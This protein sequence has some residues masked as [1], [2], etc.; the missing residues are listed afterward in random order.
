M[1]ETSSKMIL[2]KLTTAWIFCLAVVDA[3]PASKPY[4]P[5]RTSALEQ[6]HLH[7]A[8]EWTEDT[9]HS[10]GLSI[11][12]ERS[13]PDDFCPLHFS[14]GVSQRV[15]HTNHRNAGIVAP[16]IIF[17]ILPS[18]GPGR[19]VLYTTQYEHLDMLT[20]LRT[21]PQAGSSSSSEIKEGLIQ[22]VEFPLLFESSAFLTSPIVADVNGD[23]ILDAI[24]TDY[25]GGIYA[26]GLQTKDGKRYFHKAQVPRLYIRRE[27]M[28]SRVNE[29]LGV[30]PN[31]EEEEAEEVEPTDD[32]PSDYT[33]NNKKR[34]SN[35][36][37]HD[38]Y[39]SYF[40]Y[41]YGGSTDHEPILRGVTAN[42]LGQDQEHVQALQTRRK[43]KTSHHRPE[44]MEDYVSASGD[45]SSEEDEEDRED[46]EETHRRLQEVVEE[47]IDQNHRRLPEGG[48]VDPN[49]TEDAHIVPGDNLNEEAALADLEAAAQRIISNEEQER[50]AAAQ[51][52]ISNEEQERKAAAEQV[53]DVTVDG[54][55]MDTANANADHQE[56]PNPSDMEDAERDEE[57]ILE[58]GRLS[59]SGDE[60]HEGKHHE[61]EGHGGKPDYEHHDDYT[62][63]HD[64]DD[65]YGG[66]YE[67]DDELNT[68]RRMFSE[69]DD[70]PPRYGDD[71]LPRYDDEYPRHDDYYGRY[72]SESEDYFDDKHYVRI[73]P[74]ILCTPVIAEFPKMY[75]QTGETEMFL[76]VAVSYYLD[77]DEYEGFFSYK[78][79]VDTDHGDETEVQR[80]MYVANAIMVYQFGDSPR[81]GRQEHLDLS[82]DHSAPVNTT[83]V[84][85]I[86]MME[87]NSKMGAFALSSP[88]VA[89]I[90]GDGT[91][92]VL[93]GTSMGFVYGLDARNLYPKENWPVQFQH[94]I[95]SR[96]L[97]EDVA[98]DTNLEIF[99]MDVGGNVA[100]LNHKAEKIWH[101]DLVRSVAHDTQGSEVLASSPMV[102]GD[103]DGDGVLDV[104]VLVKIRVPKKPEAQYI[105][106]LSADTGKDLDYF[107]MR[108]GHRDG[109]AEDDGEEFVH[110]KLPAPLLV[111]LHTDQSWLEA[112]LHRNGTKWTKPRHTQ[113]L[114]PPHGGSSI[115]LHIVQ[116]VG[117]HLIVMEAASGCSQ[118]ISIGDDI[119]TMVQADDVHGTNSLDLV[120]TTASSNIITLDSPAPFHPLN[121]WNNG[122]IRGRTNT[123]AHGYS[124]SQGIFVHEVSRQ[125]RDIFGVYVPVTFEIFDNRPNIENEPDKRVYKV[126]IREGTSTP[127]FRKEYTAPGVYT[128]RVYI[129]RGPGYYVLSVVLTST[130]GLVYEDTFHFGYNVNYMQGF[131]L[132]LWLPL[133]IASICIF[134]CATKKSRWED[135][136]YEG[137]SQ[138]GRLSGILGNPL[139]A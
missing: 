125:F 22:H 89:D 94:G 78:R 82:G 6:T 4:I 68:D 127:L 47:T 28:E 106:V 50:D 75:T 21:P 41:T 107:P 42:V 53:E 58:R 39:H 34:R 18:Q 90:D 139:P 23:G 98:G 14:L 105:F 33:S 137:D 93:M 25:D 84:G 100:C 20:P 101:R 55:G 48:D 99:V 26:M 16:P 51:Q 102:L 88:T 134:L 5:F 112:Y 81:W 123:F 130:H 35:P 17:P 76:F 109:A 62:G 91:M 136:D 103:V 70:E 10:E 117:S 138:D 104:V 69:E 60:H 8:L 56:D 13:V 74:H 19:Q 92:E 24:L 116:P 135:D 115:G 9:T 97:V 83:L 7:H 65:M 61:H 37:P 128:Q 118:T 79:F 66:G 27:W 86:P 126:D 15:H 87:D 46:S 43:R 64:G 49:N 11:V 40:E 111:D 133:L 73:P 63:E 122:E 30:D 3:N 110:R 54:G 2:L 72:D 59:G 108:I 121:V 67:G 45:I 132:L 95:E 36:K 32:A 124:A 80:G 119:L 38:P 31:P 113:P 52:I 71:D 131:G 85:S 1:L 129:P 120:I 96:I 12:P 57:S 29:T 77:E 44:S 114:K